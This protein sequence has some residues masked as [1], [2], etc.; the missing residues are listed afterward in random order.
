MKLPSVIALAAI[1]TGAC[2]EAVTAPGACPEYCPSANLV[3][4]DTVMRQV[5]VRDSSYRGYVTAD[6]ASAMQLVWSGTT[7]TS[8]GLV[9]FFGFT[10]DVA[11]ATGALLSVVSTDSLEL[12]FTIRKRTDLSGMTLVVHRVSVA[13][14]TSATPAD[15]ATWFDDST[16][17]ATIDIP[18]S[19]TTGTVTAVVD[20]TAF[21]TF[22]EDSL[23]AAIGV[24]VRAP[25]AAYVDLGTVEGAS[26]ATLLRFVQVD[27]SGT[28]VP[29]S[30]SRDAELDTYF[31]PSSSAPPPDA[32][33]IGGIPAARALVRFSLP[34]DFVSSADVIRATLLLVPAEPVIGAPGDT[35]LLRAEKVDADIGPKSP[36][37][38]PSTD[39]ATV[40]SAF[41]PVGSSDTVRI[42][43][44]HI[45]RLWRSDPTAPRTM[46]LRLPPEAATI[47]ELRV[48]SSRVTAAAPAL[49]LTYQPLGSEGTAP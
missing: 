18:D 33:V 37:V 35:L 22:T 32:L 21:P 1:L 10:N 16:V 36:Y 19:V 13:V 47:G 26:S 49:R 39:T 25:E 28:N 31:P 17:I 42:D 44:T 20:T 14:D 48:Q 11:D 7:A 8:R 9:R 30:D 5:V 46:L 3:V 15:L 34:D 6:E 27:S 4:R 2:G 12:E 24:E 38:P 23:R 43:V 41:V 29:R 45:V 40:G